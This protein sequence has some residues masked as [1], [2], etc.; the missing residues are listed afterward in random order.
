MK[1][2]NRVSLEKRKRRR[3]TIAV[4]RCTK[5]LIIPEKAEPKGVSYR[6]SDLDSEQ[7]FYWN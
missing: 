6:E 3:H 4:F 5:D 2:L 7:T 1:E